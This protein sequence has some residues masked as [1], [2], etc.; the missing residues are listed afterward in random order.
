[1]KI[2]QLIFYSAIA[3][4]CILSGCEREIPV[5][6]SGREVDGYLIEGSVTNRFGTPLAHV[7]VKVDYDLILID[8]ND[9][10]PRY[11]EITASS[12]FV[13]VV[14]QE[15]RGATVRTLAAN[16]F[17]RG[18]IEFSW[19]KRIPGGEIA[20]SGVYHVR[21][22]VGGRVRHS[23]PV[24]VLNSVT[25]RTNSEGSFVIPDA[26]L[27]IGYEPIPLY[28]TG[29]SFFYGNHRIGSRVFL[30]FV[31]GGRTR[32]LSVHPIKNRATRFDVILN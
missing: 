17:Q 18:R 24:L 11:Y 16:V 25:A 31:A 6:T 27:P 23:Y 5:D 30:G 29:S 21:Y 14:V 12:E 8:Q 9:P 19:D 20:P 26:R 4:V 15:E 13:T 10:A 22:L 28:G 1:M 2:S 3:A 32:T 7:D